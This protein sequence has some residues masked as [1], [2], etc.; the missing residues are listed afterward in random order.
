MIPLFELPGDVIKENNNGF[1]KVIDL[2]RQGNYKELYNIVVTKTYSG[3]S[4]SYFGDE[5]W[6]LTAYVDGKITNKT[7]M[8]FSEISNEKLAIEFKIIVF[9]WMYA[10]G[11]ARKS[12]T[13]KPA[14][15]IARHSKL[16]STYKY[17]DVQGIESITYLANVI[18]FHQYCEYIE[19]QQHSVG[20]IRLILNALNHVQR[21][22]QITGIN[23]FIPIDR[24]FSQ[25]AKDIADTRSIDQKNQFYAIPTRIMEKLYSEATKT[26]T[27]LHP[28]KENIHKLLFDLRE[29]YS[30][31]KL[32][33]DEKI[34]SGVWK[35]I[36]KDSPNYRVEVNKAK[37][38][39]YIDIINAHVNGSL[40][41]KHVPKNMTKIKGWI[42][43]VQASCFIICGAYTGM[44]R[45]ELYG[46]H[47]NSFKTTALF[48][49]NYHTLSSTYHKMTQGRGTQSEWITVPFV[50]QA[51]ELAEA[52]VRDLKHQ[53]II[54]DDPMS[55]HNS[56]CLWLGQARKAVLPKIR[57]EGSMREQFYRIAKKANAYITA[58]DLEEFK[59]INPNSN[60]LH[61]DRKIKIGELWPITTHQFRRTFAVF[62]KRH[63][64]CS[65][66]AIKQQFKQLDLP[67][68][69]WYGQGGIASK[70]N[71]LHLD[72]E[73]KSLLNEVTAEYKTETIH[74]WY[75][76]GDFLYGR[77]GGALMRERRELPQMYKSWE[78]IYDHVKEGRLDLVG[79]MHSYCLAGYECS[80]KKVTSPANCMNCENQLIDKDQAMNWKSR[81]QKCCEMLIEYELL[82][83]L[84]QSIYSHFITQIKA[85]EKVM[86]YFQI[87]F[88]PL[89]FNE[90]KYG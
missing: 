59:L 15:L 64:L 88:K 29:N 45:S 60:P 84:N 1:N 24:T 75:N 28:Y 62:A 55:V 51:I 11:N 65:D 67:T 58:E 41:E 72:K 68:A 13:I 71:N 81:Y 48:N 61:A 38:S 33:V 83:T 40:L 42:S 90:K 87:E 19:E 54:D 37:P 26:I 8:I 7:K 49:K 39:N 77:M 76:R 25:L 56:S 12:S 78:A 80:M 9:T 4:K 22:A 30:L 50:K 53:L 89:E 36:T 16:M 20:N 10:A 23:F 44:R 70:L 18:I 32:I 21:L 85:A 17:L 74:G 35:W 82:G 69:E 3:E 43:E 5:E 6:D 31:G 86:K 79:T 47:E 57:A 52:I 46:L 66:V 63:S 73:L 34:D 2:Y 14:T 27:A